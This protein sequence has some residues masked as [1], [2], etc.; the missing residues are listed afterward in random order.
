MNFLRKVL[1][2]ALLTPITQTSFAL[3]DSKI[4]PAAQA[5]TTQSN[6]C[7]LDKNKIAE[8]LAKKYE[9]F[10]QKPDSGWREFESK[11]CYLSGAIMADIYLVD[12]HHDLDETQKTSI[13][14]QSGQLYAYEGATEIALHRFRRS[15][16]PDGSQ[17]NDATWTAFI[18]ATMAFLKKDK[19]A[20]LAKREELSKATNDPNRRPRLM[21]TVDKFIQCFEQSYLKAY[22]HKCE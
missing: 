9:D 22:K 2:C 21:A 6:Q 14:Y 5:S 4:S 12:H 17:K 15:I 16:S 10:A 18:G 1:V 11:G 7:P 8:M 20:L 13:L 3:K 19:P